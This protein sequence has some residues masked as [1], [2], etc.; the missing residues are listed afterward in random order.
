M[1]KRTLIVALAALVLVV[2]GSAAYVLWQRQFAADRFAACDTGSVAG[3]DIGGPFELT[4]ASDGARVTED[5][6]IDG[7]TLIYFGY[8]YCPDIC[9]FDLARNAEAVDLLAR[10][11]IEVKPVFITVDPARDTRSVM[12]DYTGYMHPEMVGL[13]GSEA[14]IAAARAAYRVYAAPAGGAAE[15]AD[16]LV[17]HTTFSYLMTPQ[18]GLVAFFRSDVAA[19]EMADRIACVAARI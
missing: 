17:D 10:R 16:Y 9:P 7:L 3:A 1:Q 12:A 6:V 19:E 5:A 15:G 2:L 8:T 4:R 18:H 11:G 14:D 13:T